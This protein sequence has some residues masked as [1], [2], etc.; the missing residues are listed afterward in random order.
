MALILKQNY[1]CIFPLFSLPRKTRFFPFGTYI[2]CGDPPQPLVSNFLLIR[3]GG[4]HID[5]FRDTL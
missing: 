4:G 1:L 3:G 2:A 5:Y